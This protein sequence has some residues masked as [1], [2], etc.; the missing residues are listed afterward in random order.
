ME[1]DRWLLETY[2][3]PKEDLHSGNCLKRS[4]WEKLCIFCY[5]LWLFFSYAVYVLPS[6]QHILKGAEGFVSSQAVNEREPGQ[7]RLS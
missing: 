3:V 4:N 7:L 6:S 1:M 2:L 5:P